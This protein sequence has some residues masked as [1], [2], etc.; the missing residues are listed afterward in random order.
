MNHSDFPA[1]PATLVGADQRHDWAE[2]GC[3]NCRRKDIIIWELVT[4]KVYVTVDDDESRLTESGDDPYICDLSY[5]C[6]WCGFNEEAPN[7]HLA[8]VHR[9]EKLMAWWHDFDL[10][11]QAEEH[12]D[13]S[14][15]WDRMNIELAMWKAT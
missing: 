10:D 2:D 9:Y 8:L 13:T 1:G 3:P 7:S 4:D 6:R 5:E 12:T 14:E 11:C 15:L